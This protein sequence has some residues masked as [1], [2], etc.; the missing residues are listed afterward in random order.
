MQHFPE[1]PVRGLFAGAT[2]REEI[3]AEFHHRLRDSILAAKVAGMRIVRLVSCAVLALA[4]P[5]AAQETRIAALNFAPEDQPYGASLPLLVAAVR[6]EAAD[7]RIHVLPGGALAPFRIATELRQRQIDIASLA[8]RYYRTMM[9]I[10]DA[11]ELIERSPEELRRNGG[12][13][14][15]D[16]LHGEAMN[17]RLLAVF[18]FA[19]RYHIYLRERRIER[20]AYENVKILAPPTSVALAKKMS[21]ALV[22]MPTAEVAEALDKGKIEGL[23]WPAWEVA[24]Y[25]WAKRLKFKIE[26]GFNAAT[27][28]ILI[29]RASWNALSAAHRDALARAARTVEAAEAQRAGQR[30]AEARRLEEEAGVSTI[31]L[32]ETD[33]AT[34]VSAAHEVAWEGLGSI[35]PENTRRLRAL[36]A[37]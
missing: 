34:L 28:V 22:Q 19:A 7:L 14:L 5:A 10:A 8:P 33:A 26:P 15:L 13:E 1:I 24:S 32:G 27:W 21:A 2:A 20:L 23:I 11:L 4:L 3:K 29:N 30:N 12:F 6:P 18:G 37:K 35:D 16:R 25:G 31:R 9:P 36:L 17:A